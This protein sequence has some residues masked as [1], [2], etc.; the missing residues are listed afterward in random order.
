MKHKKHEERRKSYEAIK[1]D[2]Y[3]WHCVERARPAGL[4]SPLD[5]TD[6]FVTLDKR[7]MGFDVF[8]RSGKSN[9]VPVCIDPS[10]FIQYAQFWTPRS[11][12][13]EKALFGSLRLPLLFRD[14]DHDTEDV[15]VAILRRMAA[16]EDVHTF[17]PT[18]LQTILLNEAVRSRF[19]HADSSE[20]EV[21]IIQDELLA[22]HESTVQRVQQ[23]ETEMSSKEALVGKQAQEAES[24]R[25]QR[26]T[27]EAQKNRA[28]DERDLAQGRAKESDERVAALERELAAANREKSETNQ[29]LVAMQAKEMAIA[30]RR[31][32]N[33]A[34]T[35][36]ISVAGLLPGL[37]V[38]LAI[39][40][41]LVY[42][43]P[44]QHF[45][46]PAVV[47]G[48]LV[49]FASLA[50]F[51]KTH[52][53]LAPFPLLRRCFAILGFVSFG[54]LFFAKETASALY[55]N[56]VQSNQDRLP[57]AITSALGGEKKDSVDKE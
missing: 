2:V 13:F 49:C 35:A 29:Q 48:C 51:G 6:W 53:T 18:E 3:M 32:R 52:A 27:F 28:S 31:K 45:V 12:E 47:I 7:L 19:K 55:Q 39:G 16:F 36:Y 10:S 37:I 43:L 8:K 22:V 21:K 50:H 41:L 15:T 44:V 25:A 34:A 33:L 46:L 5:A 4:A 40:V 20:E 54:A 38:A 30:E 17:A 42:V 57:S 11:A 9:S 24:L 26:D 1:H 23:L 56:Y 14:F